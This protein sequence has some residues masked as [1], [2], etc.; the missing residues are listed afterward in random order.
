MKTQKTLDNIEQA[1]ARTHKLT[2]MGAFRTLLRP[3]AFKRRAG[4]PNWS[5]EVHTVT[6]VTQTH[7]TDEK[8]NT[9]DT[10]LVLPVPARSSTLLQ[11]N[12]AA[13]RD[14]KRRIATQRFLPDFTQ[15]VARAGSDG[16]TLSAAARAMTAKQR[17][18]SDA[19]R[20]AD[21]F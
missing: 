20:A 1:Q 14:D 16:M 18:H 13:P 21:D 9:Y 2:T 3:T 4:V 8:G 12:E 7:V 15:I 11:R 6:Q 10:R 5:S 19:Q 17:V